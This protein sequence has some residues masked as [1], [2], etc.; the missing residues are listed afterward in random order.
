VLAPALGLASQVL[1]LE[2]VPDAVRLR[3]MLA[4]APEG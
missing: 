4:L 2:H 1:A 3:L